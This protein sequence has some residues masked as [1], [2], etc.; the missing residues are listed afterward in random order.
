M[1]CLAQ[2]V[3]KHRAPKGALRLICS[4][5]LPFL[6]DPVRKQ[7]APKGAL[8]PP[9]SVGRGLISPLRHKAPSAKRCIK[10]KDGQHSHS[11]SK[12][13]VIKRRAPKGALRLL[14]ARQP[15]IL[16][17]HVRK[18]RAPKGALRLH[19]VVSAV[20]RV[21]SRK[22]PSAKRCIKTSKTE[23]G[24]AFGRCKKAPSAKRCIKTGRHALRLR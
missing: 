1:P 9:Q 23:Y 17:G 10:T 21:C 24:G 19:G 16:A 6:I 5:G 2:N 8:R 12:P 18:H 4:Q 20:L 13:H 3:R 15:E 7:Q 22:A 14:I 11:V